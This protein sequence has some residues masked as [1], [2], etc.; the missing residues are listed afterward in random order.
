MGFKWIKRYLPRSFSGRVALIMLVP[1][2]T[3]QLV[4]SIVFIQ[5]HY[6]GVT[7]QMTDNM[8]L[9][10]SFIL[11]RVNALDKH[12]DVREFALD[13]EGALAMKITLASRMVGQ[14]LHSFDDLSGRVIISILNSGLDGV[15]AVD[16]L[17]KPKTIQLWLQTNHG[18]MLVQFPRYRV[19]ATNPHQLLVL[20]IFTGILMTTIAFLFMRNQIRPIKRLAV[21]AEAFGKGHVIKYTPSGATEVRAA[22]GAFLDM[23]G[24]IERHIEQRTLMLSGVSHDLRTPLTR[25]KLGLSMMEDTDEVKALN[26]D[27]QDMTRLLDEFLNF[28]KGDAEDKM[29]YCEPMDV[30]REVADA[31]I[32]RG[33]DLKLLS[34]DDLGSMLLRPTSLKRALNNLLE[35]AARYANKAT[36][37]ATYSDDALV[38]II[39]DNGPGIAR[40]AREEAITPFARLEPARNQ[41]K[42]SGV[43]LGLAITSDIA[44]AH[45]GSLTLHSSPVLGGLKAVITFAR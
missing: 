28:A 27:V 16:L 5:R 38:V 39:E 45:G 36:I 18:P 10:L 11:E 21:A 33:G 43:G 29:V 7:R 15:L 23:R 42:G 1:I 4:V 35:N 26:Q 40:N 32:A 24:R 6:E 25:F 3:L 22:G 30:V 8:V 12:Q 44:R 13:V 2:I 37:S 31:F 34:E 19:A 14:T 41:N 17:S 9:E 20:M